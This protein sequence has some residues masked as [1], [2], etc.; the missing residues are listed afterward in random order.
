MTVNAGGG[1]IWIEGINL[2][3]LENKGFESVDFSD[4]LRKTGVAH[5]GVFVG[6]ERGS[7]KNHK[8]FLILGIIIISIC[9]AGF[10]F[11]GG[12][13]KPAKIEAPSGWKVIYPKDAPPRL[14][15]LPR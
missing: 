11:W 12:G 6:K 4:A 5:G 1:I 3:M 9:V 10:F 13:S 14:E 8:N 2:F 7:R 15:K